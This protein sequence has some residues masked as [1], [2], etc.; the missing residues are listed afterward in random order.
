VKL[1]LATLVVSKSDKAIR[2][3]FVN[4]LILVSVRVRK[5]GRKGEVYLTRGLGEAARF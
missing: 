1:Y 3:V 4:W 5:F 2:E